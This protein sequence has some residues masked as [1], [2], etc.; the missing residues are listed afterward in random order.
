MQ[1]K[2]IYVSQPTLPPLKE[3]TDLLE[4]V[5]E[6]GILT[7]NGP[8]VQRLEKEIDEYLGANTT[9]LVT[10]GTIALHLA[11]RA[12]DLVEGEVITTPFSWISSV[13]AIQWEGCHPVFVDVD[14][15]TFNIDPD[16]IEAA[17]T[18][19]TRAILGVH[20][21]SC[22]CDVERIEAIASKHNLK[23]IYDG[24][25]A[26]GVKI[27]EESIFSWGDIS[28]TSL[29]ALKLLNTGEGGAIFTT[30]ALKEK[31][32]SLRFFGMDSKNNITNL[33]T[34]AKM[35]EIQAALGLCNLPN[36]TAGINI[37][38]SIY[39]IYY[40]TLFHKVSFQKFN[41]ASY[42]YS[43]MPV[44]FYSEKELLAVMSHLNAN[45]IFPRRY[46][47]PSLNE[48]KAVKQ[49]TPCPVSEDLSRRILCLPSYNVL[50]YDS[51]KRISE[52]ILEALK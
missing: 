6:T 13:S 8:M 12:L 2:P 11:L 34:N 30:G 5:W 19:K 4:G 21:F 47:F 49:Y 44:I 16:K 38:K 51:V 31:I 14:P 18:D 10:N 36:V 25:H 29:H 17:I 22:P 20:V 32:K 33:G 23:V 40:N 50:P 35:T 28:T 9:S 27:N 52:L 7:H 37:R 41:L 24:A 45:N 15:E 43:Y 42:N 46:F 1:N 48:V 39:S 26:F 3:Y